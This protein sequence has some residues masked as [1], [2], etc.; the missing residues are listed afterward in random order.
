VVSNYVKNAVLDEIRLK[1]IF[2]SRDHHHL[3]N[4]FYKI[5]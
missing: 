4:R 1:H 3:T 5:E 2:I